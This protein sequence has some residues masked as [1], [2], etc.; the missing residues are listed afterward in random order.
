MEAEMQRMS[1]SWFRMVLAGVVVS[2][3]A[4]PAAAQAPAGDL[5][6]QVEAAERGFAKSMADRDLRAFGAF[7]AD[8]AVFFSGPE[9]RRGKQ[10]VVDWWAR[11]FA[12]GTPA[13]FSWEPDHVEVLP[14]GTLALSTGPVK[15]PEGKVVS[16]FNSIW[17]REP[18]GRWRIVFDKGE[19]APPQP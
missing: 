15:D 9:P 7:V 10:Q 16:R 3:L 1:T 4:S 2:C 14:S 17:R 5:K 8:D 12:P 6:A 19:P 18:D 13:P 11:F